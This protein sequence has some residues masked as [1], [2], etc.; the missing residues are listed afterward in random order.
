MKV[1]GQGDRSN[2]P[3]KTMSGWSIAL[4]MVEIRLLEHGARSDLPT[5]T[6]LLEHG[7]RTGQGQIARALRS[8]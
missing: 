3:A 8:Q 4:T 7:A 2:L 5:R 1:A 6:R